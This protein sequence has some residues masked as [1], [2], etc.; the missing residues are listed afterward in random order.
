MGINDLPS[1]KT[2]R[3]NYLTPIDYDI[4]KKKTNN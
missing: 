4:D 2:Q 1:S 3:H